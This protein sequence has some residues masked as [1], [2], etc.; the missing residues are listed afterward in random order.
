M[1]SGLQYP[2]EIMNGVLMNVLRNKVVVVTGASAGVG[3]A[4]AQMMAR[5]GAKLALLAR[6]IEK[7]RSTL[8][9]LNELG[10]QAYIY[11]VDVSDENALEEVAKKIELEIGPIDIWINNAM[12]TM[13]GEVKD[14]TTSEVRRVMEVNFIGSVNGTLVAYR[15]FLPRNQGHIIQVGSALAYISIPLQSAYCAS[16]HAVH[17]F[18]QSLRI[19][20]R[21]SQSKIELSEVH[22][23]AVNTPQFEWMKNHTKKHPM[24]VPP[25]FEPELMAQA[26]VA[27]AEFPKK[28]L[29]VGFP[30]IKAII[31]EKLAPWLAEWK[32]KISGFKSQQTEIAPYSSINNM[33]QPVEKD[34]GARGIFSGQAKGRS[35]FIWLQIWLLK[36]RSFLLS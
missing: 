3:R 6:G 16:K 4:I 27:I 25:I 30:T 5:K 29:W 22:L 9:D 12:V 28:E 19:E 17:G 7:L 2:L 32:L 11:S 15:R 14:I 31:A 33:W 26:V 35:F 20:L 24:P 13:I 10:A 23:P 8:L 36:W 1:V 34:Y 18:I 21:A